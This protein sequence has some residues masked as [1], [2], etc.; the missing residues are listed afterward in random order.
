MPPRF[1]ILFFLFCCS[2]CLQA[3][4]QKA[5][6][7][8]KLEIPE[9]PV[10]DTI[11]YHTGFSLVYNEQHEQALWVAYELTKEETIKKFNRTDKFIPDPKVATKTATNQ[12]YE[13]SGYDRGHLAPAADMSWS[14]ASMAESFYFSNMSPQTPSFNRGIWKKLEEQTRVWAIENAK[15]Y[16][17]TGPVLSKDLP[18]IG[19]NKVSIPKYYYKV[20]LDYTEP[21]IKGIG[22]IMPNESSSKPLQSFA[23]SIDSV[24]A[25][26]GINFFPLLPNKQETVI[27]KTVCIPCWTWPAAKRVVKKE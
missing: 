11:I 27:E 21:S 14:Q 5:Q 1:I 9:T 17:I 23:V 12:D 3:Q 4:P 2:V 19:P 25:V 10:S 16:I 18:T 7:I 15:I 24:E 22:F 8:A 26:T 6:T 20:I 13:A